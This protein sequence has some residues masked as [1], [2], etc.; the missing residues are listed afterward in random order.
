MRPGAAGVPSLVVTNTNDSG[1]GSLRQAILDANASAV[2]ASVVFNIPGGGVQTITPA[3]N[4]PIITR[5]MSIDGY[6]QPGSTFNSLAQGTNAVLKVEI[7]GSATT[8]GLVIG[9]SS[10]VVRGLV[11]NRCASAG[12]SLPG[13]S[14]NAIEGNFIGTDPTGTVARP[15]ASFGILLTG[16][17]STNVIGGGTGVSKRNLISGN[18]TGR[19]IQVDGSSNRVENNLIGTDA[20]GTGALP[21][22]S[23][24]SLLSSSNTV[25]GLTLNER[26]V[27]SGNNGP[28]VLIDGAAASSNKVQGNLI[29]V[30]ASG[31]AAL[32][33][34]GS[35]V[36]IG[37]S[38]SGSN[39]IGGTVSTVGLPP[40]NVISGNGALPVVGAGVEV[41]NG[42]NVNSTSIQGNLVGT[43]SS[44]VFAIPNTLGIK[45]GARNTAITNNVVSG[46]LQT[47]ALVE[48]GTGQT[49]RGNKIGTDITGAGPLPNGGAGILVRSAAVVI[50]G[51]NGQNQQNTIAFNNAEGIR[52]EDTARAQSR[53]NF[54]FS[55]SGLGINLA[56]AGQGPSVVTPNDPGD[57]DTGPS[58]LQNFPVITNVTTGATTV[59][60][61]GTLNSLPNA[62]FRLEFF[63][64]T[65]PDP[66]GFGEG[67]VFL[68]S[69]TALTNASGD[70]SFNIVMT[71]TL[72]AGR[73]VTATATDPSNNTSEFSRA[74]PFMISPVVTN[75]G[76]QISSEGDAVSLQIMA[77]DPD[78]QPLTFSASGLPPGLSINPSTGLIGGILPFTAAGVFNASVTASDGALSDTE[79]FTWTVLGTNRPPVI[80]TP[81]DQ[82]NLEDT[83]L[84]LQIMASDPDADELTFTAVGLPPDLSI[85]HKTGNISGKLSFTSAGMWEVT[86]FATDGRATSSVNFDW[87][88]INVNRAPVLQ[89]PGSQSNLEGSTVL[90]PLSA[91]DPDTDP[92]TFTATGLPPNLTIHPNSGTISGTLPFTSSGVYPVTVTVSDG[93]FTDTET[94]TWT[95]G[96]VNR[97]PVLTNPGPQSAIFRQPFLLRLSASDP[98]GD[99]LTFSGTGLPSGMSIDTSGLI[100]GAATAEGLFTVS[101]TVTDGTLS[102]TESFTLTVGPVA[103]TGGRLV[104]SRRALT[105][106][107]TRSQR[108]QTLLLNVSNR[109]RGPLSVTVE[110]PADPFS[111]ANGGSFVIP[112]GGRRVVEVTFS[113]STRGRFN[114]GLVIHTNDPANRRVIVKLLGKA[115]RL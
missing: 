89:N 26:N 102:D 97:A 57:T 83:G 77:S 52:V 39:Q 2:F 18:T 51:G 75:P 88:V 94:F 103:D 50:T 43:D 66:T 114:R 113:P 36:S 1:A 55:N 111:V 44:G 32:P 5:S 65:S 12:I 46:N 61:S 48:V 47:G 4:L 108:T 3:S 86:V 80:V 41:Q 38:A 19:A 115:A 82:V 22:Q 17:A 8:F 20:S 34:I 84:N 56:P 24:I 14:S 107:A 69:G 40:G 68:G 6:T 91:A 71:A 90:L 42:A 92:M 67:E 45:N 30:T 98:D 110:D 78:G 58:Q 29:G 13:T 99:A 109:G 9:A 72:P 35:G 81:L 96:G 28:G 63:S 85:H 87:R 11:I 95:V 112:P 15:N 49:V 62:S 101:V 105:F 33:N 60:V 64:N 37:P 104:L 25:G 74:F 76:P 27:I 21:N 73:W 106:S 70:V 93:S 31:N 10:C 79:N 53:Q 7:N 59:T 23:G 16:G 54:I 100:S